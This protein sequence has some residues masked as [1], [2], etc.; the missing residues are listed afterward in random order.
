[1]KKAELKNGV[2]PM[3]VQFFAEPSQEPE[4]NQNQEPEPNT[5]PSREPES[6]PQLSAEE[7]L[8]QLMVENIK[9][10]KAQEKAASEAAD[11]KKKYN[12]TLTDKQKADQEKAEKEAE[13]EEQFNKLLKENTVTKYEKN[14]LSLGYPE[15]LANKAAV[16]QY[17]GDTESLFK[18]QS[19]FQQKLVKERE[20]EWLKN[21]PDVQAG[22]D[23]DVEKT[24]PF[25]K[26]F[27]M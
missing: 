26:G 7:Q 6:E 17:D 18:I 22:N 9:L 5:E 15:D 13:R 2:L 3:N 10:K 16:A 23:E 19:D 11:Y 4:P 20:T 1:M 27:D 24:D 21:R 12:A 25:L 8:Q 14:F